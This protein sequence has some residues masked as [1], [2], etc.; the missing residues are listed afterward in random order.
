MARTSN[1]LT[2]IPVSDF[3][4]LQLAQEPDETGF[5][6]AIDLMNVD[7]DYQGRVRSRDGYTLFAT[8]GGGNVMGV[9]SFSNAA[10]VEQLAVITATKGFSYTTAGVQTFSTNLP[11]T[12]SGASF[13]QDIGTG[14]ANYLAAST[15]GTAAT[16]L[17]DTG[18]WAIATA[19]AY[20]G[21][22]S[23]TPW[24]NRLII[25]DGSTVRFSDPGDP[26]TFG[27]NNFVTLDPGDG[28]KITA[29]VTWGNQVFVFK[30][31]KF[32]GFYGTSTA[33]DGN[34][35]F[36]YRGVRS[37]QGVS[38]YNGAVSTAEGVYFL[39]AAGLWVTTGGAPKKVSGQIDPIFRD[40][41]YLP[42]I[43]SDLRTIGNAI[44]MAPKAITVAD[45]KVILMSS[46]GCFGVDRTSGRWTIDTRHATAGTG[47]NTYSP[48]P[49]SDG[50][51]AFCFTDGGPNVYVRGGTTDNGAAITSRYRTGFA[52]LGAGNEFTVRELLLTGFGTLSVKGSINS[53]AG[54][55]TAETVGLGASASDFLQGRS[56]V[57]GNVRGRSVS[58][59]VSSTEQWMLLS[60]LANVKG[61]QSVGEESTT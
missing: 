24:D 12:V 19:L 50:A 61:A 51:E 60:M 3:G 33:G 10:G 23:T 20:G 48:V 47:L 13:F 16:L 56:R 7:F 35:I 46:A 57:A 39:N 58:Y 18:T 11:V 52:Q 17:F 2:P 26:T 5:S 6:G 42:F 38:G 40:Q 31:T 25:C 32:Y 1:G 44:A 9:H 8:P 30:Q 34:P 27:V 22:L 55:N 59:Q 4:G 15:E 37:Q 53:H 49:A 21:P 36:N 29:A 28:E 54:L 14:A 45:G 43:G 41:Q